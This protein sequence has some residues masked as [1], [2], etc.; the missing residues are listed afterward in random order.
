MYKRQVLNF[1]YADLKNWDWH[2]GDAGIPVLP[3]QQLNGKYRIWMD[4]DVLQTVFVQYIGI[5][6]CNRIKATLRDFVG[7]S[8]MWKWSPR[9]KITEQEILRRSYYLGSDRLPGSLEKKR[10]DEFINQY[11]LS[12]L[13]TTQESLFEQGGGYD[14]DDYSDDDDESEDSS[15][16][17]KET[18]NIKQKLLRKIVTET[19]LHRQLYG[20]LLY[21]S[22][23]ADE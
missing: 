18:G 20:C 15:E 2:A 23:A 11:L 8:G 9:P 4:E 7:S 5:K 6:L 3:R 22:D 10:K 19:L 14:D 1:R 13:P 16:G 21:T 12:Q 17:S